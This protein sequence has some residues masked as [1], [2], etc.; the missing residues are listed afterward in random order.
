MGETRVVIDGLG[1]PE[2]TRLHEGRVWLGNWGTG[3]ML[4]VTADGE[5]ELVARL[6]HPRSTVDHVIGVP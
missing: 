2:S 5:R 1:L 6:A 3:E 4:A